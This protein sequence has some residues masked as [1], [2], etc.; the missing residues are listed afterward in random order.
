MNPESFEHKVTS[1][2]ANE[3]PGINIERNIDSGVN[4]TELKFAAEKYEQRSES[5]VVIGDVNLTTSLPTPVIN[6]KDD[7]NTT[8]VG[9]SIELPE[10]GHSDIIEKEWVEIAKKIV[11]DNSGDPYKQ[12]KAINE[13]QVNYL[14]KR[15][16]RETGI[17]E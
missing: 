10:A 9:S 16:G 12:E 7:K 8:L 14:K 4:E 6:D 13:L 3:A 11:S 17:S 1:E 5:R 15:Y 2:R